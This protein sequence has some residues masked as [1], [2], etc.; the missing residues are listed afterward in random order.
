VRGKRRYK[1]SIP[2]SILSILSNTLVIPILLI[3]VSMPQVFLPSL[4]LTTLNAVE[5]LALAVSCNHKTLR[6][7]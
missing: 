6:I 4:S 3:P 2:V 7:N 5:S 1:E